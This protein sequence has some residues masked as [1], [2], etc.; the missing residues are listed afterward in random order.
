[1]K[2][3]N[4]IALSALLFLLSLPIGIVAQDYSF[5]ELRNF[6]R[7]NEKLYRG[8]QLRDGGIERLKELGIKSIIDLRKNPQRSR[9]EASEAVLHG[10]RYFNVPM[11]KFGRPS[12]EKVQKV[13]SI[14]NNPANHPVFVHCKRGS[15]RTGVVIA[16]YRIVLDGWTLQQAQKE[17]SGYGMYWWMFRKKGYVEDFY[18]RWSERKEHGT[19][20]SL[21]VQQ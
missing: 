13:L 2:I 3:L 4:T 20:P 6:H 16:I 12:D 17:A 10:L 14:V 15:D 1:M 11:N 21:V 5:E 19:L 7:V 8:G 18:E 9:Q